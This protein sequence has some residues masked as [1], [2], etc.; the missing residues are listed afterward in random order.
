MSI[1]LPT[2]EAWHAG[3]RPQCVRMALPDCCKQLPEVRVKPGDV[4]LTEGFSA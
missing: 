4:L 3:A 1:I 2:I